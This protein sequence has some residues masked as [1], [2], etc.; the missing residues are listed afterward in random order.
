MMPL[1]QKGM[2]C[3]KQVQNSSQQPDKAESTDD[4]GSSDEPSKEVPEGE[5]DAEAVLK[6]LEVTEYHYSSDYW[7]YAFLIIQNNSPY[8]LSISA[9]A[10]FYDEDGN[11]V[12]AKSSGQDAIES[13]YNTLV[14]FMPDEK[15]SK[16]EYELDVSEEEYYECVQSD[17]SYEASEAEDKIILS[18]TNN[19]EEPAEFVEAYALFFNGDTPV[20][21]TSNYITDDDNELKPGKTINQEMDCYEDFDSYKVFFS[22]RR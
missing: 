11:L 7:N 16:M 12:G 22:G 3:R 21:F 15:Y 5:F 2:L 4:D 6:Q 19:G 1:F 18:V 10:N 9:N 13:G 14:Y 20:G 17:L 8:N